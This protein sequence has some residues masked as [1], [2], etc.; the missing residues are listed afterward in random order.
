MDCAKSSDFKM[1]TAQM[2]VPIQL[3]AQQVPNAAE[4]H[5]VWVLRKFV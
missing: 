3:N 5:R 4:I 1:A 2:A